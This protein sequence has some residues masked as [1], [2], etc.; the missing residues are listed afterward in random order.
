[1]VFAVCLFIKFVYL[2]CHGV[3][4]PYGNQGLLRAKSFVH[5][6]KLWQKYLLDIYLL[7]MANCYT[8]YYVVSG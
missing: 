3:L 7:F 1:M 4:N 2:V 5:T 8:A 6:T